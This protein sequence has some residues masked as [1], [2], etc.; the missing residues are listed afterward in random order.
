MIYFDATYIVRCYLDEPGATEVRE[1]IKQNV[2]ACCTLGQAEASA[3]F[4]RKLREGTLDPAQLAVVLKQ[5][6]AD[7]AGSAFVWLPLGS[8]LIT[9]VR[10]AFATLPSST[11]LW[12]S[13]AVHLVS[14]RDTCFSEIYTNDRHMLAAAPHFGLSGVNVIPALEA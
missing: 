2:V 1:L 4:H 7:A 3:A 13:D 6:D 8:G 5:F 9:R 14:A 10:K 12:A 11:F